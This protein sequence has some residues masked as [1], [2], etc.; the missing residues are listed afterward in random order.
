M[1]AIAKSG[2]PSLASVL[3]PQP[4]QIRA[5]AGVAIAAGD[6]CYIT[7]PLVNGQ[8]TAL[9]S[10]GAA[11]NA[12]AKVRGY[13]AEAAANGEAVTLLRDV[14]FRY[15]AGLTAG[16][17]VFLSGAVAGGLDTVAS[18]GGTAPIGFVVDATRIHLYNS[19]Y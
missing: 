5:I 1:A 10:T 9:L 6:A 13:A 14:T 2:T 15:G 4:N 12:A 8:P 17:D 7:T 19:R 11:A 18:V 3:P 16:I